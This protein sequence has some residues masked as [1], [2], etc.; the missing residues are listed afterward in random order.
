MA[1]TAGFLSLPGGSEWIIIFLVILIIFGP[2]SLP[3]IGNAIGRGIREFKDAS[4][5]IT[6]AIEEETASEN[7]YNTYDYDESE[8]TGSEETEEAA[9][10]AESPESDSE[11]SSD[12]PESD[13][14]KD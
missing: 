7:K 9:V 3:K 14:F 2:K 6:K 1:L 4:N 8:T 11:S 13:E 12:S 5:G 10:S